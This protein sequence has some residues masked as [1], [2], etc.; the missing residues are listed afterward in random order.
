MFQIWP[1]TDIEKVLLRRK[2]KTNSVNYELVMN[3]DSSLGASVVFSDCDTKH[4]GLNDT[5][6][7]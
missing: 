5:E 7:F 4:M 2:T 1:K 6:S 3:K